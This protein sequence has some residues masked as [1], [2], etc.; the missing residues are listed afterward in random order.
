M[1]RNLNQP[2]LVRDTLRRNLQQVINLRAAV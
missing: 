1:Q 2:P